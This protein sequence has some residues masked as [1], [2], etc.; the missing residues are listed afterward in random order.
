ME[1]PRETGEQIG[2]TVLV[3]DLETVPDL[4]AVSRINGRDM[5]DEEAEEFL[6]SKFPALPL[7]KIVCIGALI[8]QHRLQGWVVQSLGAPHIGNREEPELIA[9]FV[10]RIADLRP[11]LVSFNGHSFDLPVLRY[12]AMVNSVAA[13][14]LEARGYFR[15]YSDEAVD[16]CDVLASFD[17][18]AK[19]SLDS[20]CR[21]LG[22]PGK[23]DDIQG[24]QVA[25]Y[26]K[27]GRIQAVAD[28][29]ETDVVNTYRVWL[30]YELFRGGLT[31]S[32]FGYSETAL[33]EFIQTRAAEKPHLAHFV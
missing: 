3:W 27:D 19:I 4:A 12:R 15:R 24:K 14:S 31:K 30:R 6:G 16:L 2:P 29:C 32:E 22:L 25:G 18:R 7:H 11:K 17:G 23:P 9:A 1:T 28:Y 20:L 5:S 21:V 13:P 26:V 33:R 10:D 8:A